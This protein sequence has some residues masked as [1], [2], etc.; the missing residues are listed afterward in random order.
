MRR[1]AALATIALAACASQP[2]PMAPQSLRPTANPSAVIATELAFAREAREKGQWT[3][4]RKYATDDAVWPGPQWENAKA[5]IKGLPDP[6]KA[7]VWEPDMVWSS[8]DGSFA[9]STGPATYP[10][11][12]RT[13]FTTIWQRQTDGE[14]RWVLDQGFDRAAAEPARDMITAR[15]AECAA[16]ASAF[17]DARRRLPPA[18]RGEAWQSG[19]A[20]DGTLA[21]D[22]AL[23]ADCSRVFVVTALKAGAMNE[24]FRASEGA[25][26]VPAGAKPPVC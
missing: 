12:R 16:P 5:S 25:P 14:Y 15:V 20:D 8:C 13:R 2:R 11:G 10:D 9:L 3:A 23:A 1:M 17:R 6:A 21:W 7:I 18:R 26:Q 22:T 4:F 24:V 19:K